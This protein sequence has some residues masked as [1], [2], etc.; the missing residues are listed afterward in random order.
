MNITNKKEKRVN[1][2]LTMIDDIFIILGIVLNGVSIVVGF[3]M[4][5]TIASLFLLFCEILLII[6]Y[7]LRII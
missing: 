7:V 5:F 1:R 4:G 2:W 6:M 3:I